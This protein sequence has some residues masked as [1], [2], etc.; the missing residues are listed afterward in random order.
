[1]GETGNDA[2]AMWFGPRL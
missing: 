1:G 2:K